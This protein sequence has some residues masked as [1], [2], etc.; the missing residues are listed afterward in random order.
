MCINYIVKLISRTHNMSTPQEQQPRT[1]EEA[2]AAVE[3]YDAY[4]R[5]E[6]SRD[7]QTLTKYLFEDEVIRL[8]GLMSHPQMEEISSK[9]KVIADLD[10]LSNIKFTL[11]LIKQIG[12]PVKA[13]LEEY[14]EAQALNAAEANLEGE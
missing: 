3:I 2:E 9:E 13:Q 7:F 14:R 6:K 8:H 11:Q 10:A 12:G 5:L 1:L 4:M